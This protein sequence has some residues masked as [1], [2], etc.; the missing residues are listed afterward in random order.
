VTADDDR[1]AYQVLERA[2]LSCEALL[3][4]A[5]ASP[6]L[7]TAHRHL[8]LAGYLAGD[9]LGESERRRLLAAARASEPVV[10]PEGL[11]L[12]SMHGARIAARAVRQSEFW[13]GMHEAR[14]H[15]VD[16]VLALGEAVG[17]GRWQEAVREATER[18]EFDAAWERARLAP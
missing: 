9:H 10:E 13:P 15:A 7:H 2:R 11:L 17:P 4:D 16:A 8:G 3:G 5:P 12:L 1:L 6:T 18:R 14:L